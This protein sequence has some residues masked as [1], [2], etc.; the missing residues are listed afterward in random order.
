MLAERATSMEMEAVF[1]YIKSTNLLHDGHITFTSVLGSERTIVMKASHSC[2]DHSKRSSVRLQ[3]TKQSL[4]RRLHGI[5]CI[6]ENHL[7]P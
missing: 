4:E 6:K 3:Y 1:D 5:N 7:T 2:H